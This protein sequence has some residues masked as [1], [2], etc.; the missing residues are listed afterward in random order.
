LDS[1]FTTLSNELKIHYLEDNNKSD[2]TLLMIH[3]LSSSCFLWTPLI[4]E[5]NKHKFNIYAI[6]LKGHGLSGKP[7]NGYSMKSLSEDVI[8]F[9]KKM[10]LNNVIIIGQ[11]MGADLGVLVST[12]INDKIIGCIGID[13]GAINL[14]QKFL[15]K[16]IALKALEP[17]NM[18][19]IDK[20]VMLNRMREHRKDWSEEAIQGQFSIFEV[21]N[22]NKIKKRLKLENHMKILN[23]LWDNS[24]IENL[25]ASKVP[26]YLIL[27]KFDL[28]LNKFKNKDVKIEIKQVDGDHDIHAQKPKLV[29][30]LIM[31]K[32]KGNFFE[33]R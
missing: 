32:I 33:K 20:D 4:K 9:I 16:K 1:K 5:L 21:D 22:N 6:D 2:T 10:K 15:I 25:L 26:I 3:G 13:G 29:S 19:G 12:K 11:S 17:P 30:D 24:P 31:K 14:K 23:G 18:E 8:N 28:N 7:E 27:V